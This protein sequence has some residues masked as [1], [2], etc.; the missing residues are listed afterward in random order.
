[1]SDERRKYYVEI[2]DVFAVEASSE[3]A[4]KR[5]VLDRLGDDPFQAHNAVIVDSE[6][7]NQ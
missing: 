7:V 2:D 3:E 5:E 6:E 1:M 4:A